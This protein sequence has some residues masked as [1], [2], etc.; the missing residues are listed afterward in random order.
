MANAGSAAYAQAARPHLAVLTRWARSRESH[1]EAAGETITL[2]HHGIDHVSDEMLCAELDALAASLQAA[3]HQYRHRDRCRGAT[4]STALMSGV[5]TQPKF[6]RSAPNFLYLF[7]HR[8]L[9]ACRRLSSRAW[10]AYGI[11]A[12][13][14]DAS[15]LRGWG[16]RGR[17]LL[18][19]TAAAP[20]RMR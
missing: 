1:N 5:F 19:R 12:P 9:R 14:L 18:E 2:R 3:S 20:C 16:T 10:A 6:F 4:C 7:Q 13:R 17:D 11:A 8:A 15:H